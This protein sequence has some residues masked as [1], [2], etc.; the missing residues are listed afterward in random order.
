MKTIKKVSESYIG[1][2][3]I[4]TEINSS[5]TNDEVAGAKAVYDY[6]ETLG[7]SEYS[8]TE[9]VVGTWTNGK[10]LYEIVKTG[11][12][13]TVTTDGTAVQSAFDIVTDKVDFAFIVSS[14]VAQSGNGSIWT[15]PYY[16]NDMRYVKSQVYYNGSQQSKR[17]QVT[18][19]GTVYNGTTYYIVVRYTK[20]A[21]TATRTLNA[22]LQM[23]TGSLLDTGDRTELNELDGETL[24][25]AQNVEETKQE[26]IKQETELEELTK[27][28][29]ETSGDTIEEKEVEA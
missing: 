14:F 16:N 21:D 5:S 27:A 12:V 29:N 17:L 10:P 11:T 18:S 25:K 24:E 28:N 8:T 13:P 15:M 2:T 7:K 3:P 26:E 22:N 19:S 9:Q 1:D 6:G 23:N 20:T 4:A